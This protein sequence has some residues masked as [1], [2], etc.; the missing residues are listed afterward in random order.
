MQSSA[1]LENVDTARFQAAIAA[2]ALAPSLTVY[3]DGACPVCSR[4]IALYQRQAGAQALAWVDVSHSSAESLG[5]DLDAPRALARLHVRR[6]DGVLVHGAAAFVLMWQALPATRWLGR[7]AAVPPLPWILEGA[8]RA[9]LRLRPLWRKASAGATEPGVTAALWAELRSDHA[10]EAGAV[11]IYRGMLATSRN[12]Q[13]RAFAQRHLETEQGHLTQVEDWLPP[14]RRSLLL[15]A[16][17]VAGWLTGALPALLG[18]RAVF[19]TVAAVETF[20]DQ[21]YAHQLLMVDALPADPQR[22]ALRALLAAC[23]ADEVQ[24]R[25]EAQALLPATPMPWGLRLWAGLVAQGSAAAVALA[26]R[27]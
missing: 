13:V 3:Y 2:P 5:P 15:P 4:E 17:R 26:R 25:D 16:W 20:V 14:A 27:F 12:A 6:A 7:V 23:Q 1:E 19:A 21:H 22:S 18:P 10:G 24:H 9:F 11:C 8:Y